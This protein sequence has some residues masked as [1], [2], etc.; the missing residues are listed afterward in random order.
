MAVSHP[1]RIA[2]VCARYYP[3][4]AGIETHVHE[5]SRRMSNAG[6]NVT[7]LTSDITGKLP[8]EECKNGVQIRRFQAYPPRTDLYYAPGIYDAV[9]KGGWDVVHEQG[10][11]T[12][13]APLAMAAAKR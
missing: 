9:A 1:L 8:V 11:H 4:M 10:Y 7:I 6:H 13:V 2:L 12:F 5:V 3:Y